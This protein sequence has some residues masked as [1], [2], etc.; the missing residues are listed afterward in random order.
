MALPKPWTGRAEPDANPLFE[1]VFKVEIDGIVL[2]EFD[3]A[4]ITG[5]DWNT[6]EDKESGGVHTKTFGSNKTAYVIALTKK[7]KKGNQS[8]MLDLFKWKENGSTDVRSGSLIHYDRDGS[9][10]YRCNFEQAWCVKCPPPKGN[11]TPTPEGLTLEIELN[12]LKVTPQ[13]G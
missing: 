7:L 11:K 13:V 6:V 5:G 10:I 1:D 2:G 9:E 8:D 12:A 4:E 3:T